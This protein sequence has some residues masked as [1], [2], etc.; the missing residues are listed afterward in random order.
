M[1]RSYQD[2]MLLLAVIFLFTQH[3]I[4][5]PDV[6]TCRDQAL[7]AA[8]AGEFETFHDLAWR[9]VQK[10]RPNDPELMY[11]LARA[12]A[13]SG[14]PGDAFVMLQRLVEAGVA[15]D[16]S[17]DD[18]RRVRNLPRWPEL[19]AQITA[20]AA[21]PAAPTEPSAV[22]EAPKRSSAERT[23]RD[24]TIESRSHPDAPAPSS[25]TEPTAADA[26]SSPAEA[27]AP[28]EEAVSFEATAFNPIGLAYDAVSR[29]FIIGDRSAGR[30]MVID[31]MS[32][33][34]TN[35]VSA[36]SAGFY[37]AISAFEIDARRGDLWVASV[38][39]DVSQSAL[40]R[41]QLVSGRVLDHVELEDGV[42]SRI[43]DMVVLGDGTV[44]ALDAARSAIL[45]VRPRSRTADVACTL[46]LPDMR[47]LAASDDRIVYVSSAAG[48]S[49]VDVRSC[50]VAPVQ[51]PPD[52]DLTAVAKVRSYGRTLVLTGQR[53]MGFTIQRARLDTT[54]RRLT[55]FQTVTSTPP[56]SPDVAVAGAEVYYLISGSARS[57]IRRARLK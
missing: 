40:H 35:L 10:G 11:L 20:L 21:R 17:T 6:R 47:S 29:R 14:R 57:A 51:A 15:F 25:P 22:A 55:R 13:L 42:A 12:Q 19:E 48:I 37:D 32:H 26:P 46:R 5:C 43:I 45:R 16:D 56:V 24:A 4:D 3:A 41:L 2:Y 39:S 34:V 44:L 54:G 31:E 23:A 7:A 1:L 27:A 52:V 53:N 9:A 8:A 30:L 18:F 33:H 36:A 50:A 49:H 38:K 28:E